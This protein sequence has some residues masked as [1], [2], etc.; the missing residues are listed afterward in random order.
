MDDIRR[1]W[2]A[3]ILLVIVCTLMMVPVSAVAMMVVTGMFGGDIGTATA[4][5]GI[6]QILGTFWI[7]GV[8]LRRSGR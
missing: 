5:A 2:T 7:A 4:V 1:G 8:R 3:P 6:V